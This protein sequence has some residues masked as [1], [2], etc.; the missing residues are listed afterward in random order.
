MNNKLFNITKYTLS[1]IVCT[2]FAISF[3]IYVGLM[4]L[5]SKKFRRDLNTFLES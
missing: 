5:F 4:S 2:V 3:F 1:Y